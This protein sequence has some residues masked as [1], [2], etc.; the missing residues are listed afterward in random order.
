MHETPILY[1]TADSQPLTSLEFCQKYYLSNSCVLEFKINILG[2]KLI[3]AR[4]KQ[5]ADER[6]QGKRVRVV[7]LLEFETEVESEASNTESPL[8]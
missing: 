1:A 4:L 7:G 8:A 5:K 2:V 3:T 6:K